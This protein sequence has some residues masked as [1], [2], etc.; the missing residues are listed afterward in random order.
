MAWSLRAFDWAADAAKLASLLCYCAV[1]LL[2]CWS[3]AVI[4]GGLVLRDQFIF[5]GINF[6]S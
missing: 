5:G 3:G 1:V 4:A 6:C 2:C